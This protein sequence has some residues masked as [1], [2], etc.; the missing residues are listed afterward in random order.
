M[1]TTTLRRSLLLLTLGSAVLAPTLGTAADAPPP[2]PHHGLGR[3][4]P[5]FDPEKRLARLTEK[6]GLTAEQQAQLR[7]ILV[8][9]AAALQAIDQTPL[10]GEQRREKT[11]QLYQDNRGKIAAILTPEQR[12]QMRELRRDGRRQHRRHGEQPDA[13][14]APQS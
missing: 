12:A 2:P 6:L 10:T 14:E 3:H 13:P 5:R 7:P 8:A 11:K 9:Q 1:I 4:E